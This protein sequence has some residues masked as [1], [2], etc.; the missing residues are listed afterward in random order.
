MLR[1]SARAEA[2]EMQADNTQLL[3]PWDKTNTALISRAYNDLGEIYAQSDSKEKVAQAIIY[4]KNAISPRDSEGRPLVTSGITFNPEANFNLAQVYF[5]NVKDYDNALK[6]YGIFN[7][8]IQKGRLERSE[9]S[10]YLNDLYYN[11]G[12]IYYNYRKDW[13]RALSY[14]SKLDPVLPD[15]PHVQ[16]A[17]ANTMLHEGAYE[18]ALGRYIYLSE[19][20]DLL[21]DDLGEIKPW[22]KDHKRILGESAAVYNNLG[23]AYQKLNE[24][25]RI[26]DYQRNSLVA[27]Y[28]A[29]EYADILGEDRGIIQYNIHYIIHPEIVRSD[30]KINDNLSDNYLFNV[31]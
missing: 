5:Y 1:K 23:V 13:T 6:H 17:I 12:Y 31:H 9:Y 10:P 2:A 8:E 27:L 24:Q 18:S 16:M 4:F 22:R 19:V 3:F 15:N 30:M 28:K 26:Y 20:Y 11:L 29:G 21:V 25:K 14:W 7:N